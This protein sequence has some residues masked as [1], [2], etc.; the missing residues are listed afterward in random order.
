MP[1]NNMSREPIAQIYNI[2]LYVITF[3]ITFNVA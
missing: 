3:S 2:A 1:L